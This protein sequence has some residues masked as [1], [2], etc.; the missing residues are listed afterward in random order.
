MKVSLRDLFSA[1][2]ST[3]LIIF[4]AVE[5]PND[6]PTFTRSTPEMFMQPLSTSSPT[7]TSRGTLSPVNATVLR[8]DTPSVIVPSM[9]TF[10]PGRTTT[11]SPTATVLGSTAVTSPP[12]S[13]LATSGRMSMRSFIDRLLLSSA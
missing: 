8:L 4:E 12:R 3:S 10:S 1:D 2:S 5:S 13:T 9:G 11:V 6:L 7:P